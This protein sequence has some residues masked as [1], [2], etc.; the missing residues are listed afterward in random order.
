MIVK[1]LLTLDFDPVTNTYKELKSE[2]VKDK[3]QVNPNEKP[4]IRLEDNKY[5]INNAAMAL[6]GVVAGDRV[7]IRYQVIDNVETPVI[8]NQSVWGDKNGNKITKSQ[9]VSFRGSNNEQLARYGNVFGLQEIGSGLFKLT[10]DTVPED[11][12]IVED[13]NIVVPI[14]DEVEI[15]LIKETDNY[16]LSD[17]DF[18]EL[19][20]E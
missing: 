13:M 2:I 19:I 9:T 18:D 6:L 15:D 12:V 7:D 1:V 10:T 16:D 4:E 3:I 5:H 14:S 8:G 11:A 17:V 20:N